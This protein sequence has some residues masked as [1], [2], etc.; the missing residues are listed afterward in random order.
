MSTGCG[1]IK[2][3]GEC[4]TQGIKKTSFLKRKGGGQTLSEGFQSTF[5]IFHWLKHCGVVR[6]VSWEVIGNRGLN[7]D[8]GKVAAELAAGVCPVPL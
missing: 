6:V 5:S 3:L 4:K 2:R 7:K 1:L 8:R